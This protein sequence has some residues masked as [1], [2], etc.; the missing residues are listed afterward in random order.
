MRMSARLPRI[1][2]GIGVVVGALG[3]LPASVSAQDFTYISGV[4][5]Q[6][7]SSSTTANITLSFYGNA[8]GT[9]TSSTGDTI[10]ANSSKTYFGATMPVAS[11]FNGS[12]VVSSDQPVAAISNILGNSNIASASYVG[13]NA[14]STN[15]LLPL[16]MKNNDS[17]DTWFNIQNTGSGVATVNVAYSDGTSAPTALINAGAAHSF[18]QHT[19]THGVKVFSAIVTSDQPVAATVL[20]ERASGPSLMFAYTGF[21]AG[22][23][24]PVMPLINSNNNGTITGVQ[25]QN[26]GGTDS[27]VTVSYTPSL[28]G[29]ACTETQTILHGQS[30]IFALAAFANGANSNCAA[31]IRFV[32]TAKVTTN[33]ASQPLTVIVNQLGTIYGEAYGAFDPNAATSKVVFPL[34]VQRSFDFSGISIMNV[35]GSSTNVSCTFSGTGFTIPSTPL[36]SNQAVTVLMTPG[37]VGANYVG[38][39]TCTASGG[40]L[41]V[42]VANQLAKA[43]T[44]DQFLVYEGINQ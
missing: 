38:S 20:Q 22:S 26:A 43:L 28:F 21:N 3:L 10:A 39:G 41:I 1:L 35:G 27:S 9:L 4:Q 2:L 42:G 6:N 40:G 29:T 36:N 30:K 19:E 44:G 12:M 33:S 25:I 5:V 37:G 11:G 18:Y 32:G 34:V 24:N 13:S 31:G 8:S 15:L 16:L 23:T 7:L 17:N 14:G